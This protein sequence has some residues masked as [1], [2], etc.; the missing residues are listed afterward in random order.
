MSIHSVRQ[1][2][3]RFAPSEK[4]AARRVEIWLD[5]DTLEMVDTLARCNGVGR[6]KAIASLLT[7]DHQRSALNGSSGNPTTG[8]AI[9]TN[10][11]PT[12]TAGG[13]ASSD[14]GIWK[15]LGMAFAIGAQV[16]GES[17]QESLKGEGLAYEIPENVRQEV[18]SRLAEDC[19]EIPQQLT[20]RLNDF[21]LV[22][23]EALVQRL[24][25]NAEAWDERQQRA[26]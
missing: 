1:P 3:G 15:A 25:S 18:Q 24:L 22:W 5:A 19:P 14:S 16:L 13:G 21:E 8:G 6:G 7:A 23:F 26:A 20:A 9:P 2:D 4:P 10:S 12:P 11:V 17:H